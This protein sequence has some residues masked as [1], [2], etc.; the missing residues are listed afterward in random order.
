MLVKF[1]SAQENVASRKALREDVNE[2]LAH[3]DDLKLIHED[4]VKCC[5]EHLSSTSL[6]DADVCVMVSKGCNNYI[7]TCM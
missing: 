3:D 6:T 5:Q 4:I 2:I 1:R 7:A